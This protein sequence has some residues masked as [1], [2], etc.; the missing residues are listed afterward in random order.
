MKT[1]KIE[2]IF[3]INT[4]RSGS[5]YLYKLFKHTENSSVRHHAKPNGCGQAMR[6]YFSGET[7]LIKK[8]TEEKIKKIKKIK[9]ESNIYIETNHCFIKGF[10]WLIPEYIPQEKIGVVILTRDIQKIIDSLLRIRCSPLMAKGRKWIL[11]PDIKNYYTEPPNWFL[12]T[13]ITYKLFHLLKRPFNSDRK[14]YDWLNLRSPQIQN[15]VTK[16]EK[17]SLEWYINET[18][19]LGEVYKKKFPR[20]KYFSVDLKSLNNFEK[21][22]ELFDYFGLIP[23]EGIQELVDKPVNQKLW[24]NNK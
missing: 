8:V 1:Q 16:Y 9:T 5:G 13:E 3:C 7:E 4:G 21:V 19:E 24:Y 10:G 17:E 20:I 12:S 18:R 11:T 2:Y 23:K 22:K 14:L 15:L 6:D